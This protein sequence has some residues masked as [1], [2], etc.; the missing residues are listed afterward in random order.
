MKKIFNILL[1]CLLTLTA[2]AQD[3]PTQ[4]RRLRVQSL[5]QGAV[6]TEL[7]YQ[8]EKQGEYG[9]TWDYYR[10]S[11]D[12]LDVID[13]QMPVG[14]MFQIYTSASRG[15][16]AKGWTVNGLPY[17]VK[18]RGQYVSDTETNFYYVMPDEDI[19]LVGRFEY[20]PDAPDFQPGANA[21]DPETGTLIMDYNSDYPAG[22]TYEDYD[23]VLRFITQSLN[24]NIHSFKNCLVYDLSRSTIETLNGGNYGGHM[25]NLS[26][27]EILLPST[28]KKIE[29]NAFMGT[30]LQTLICFAMTP[31][32]LEFNTEYNEETG[33][34]EWVESGKWAF[35][36]CP[37]MVVRV[38]AEAVELYKQAKGW[39]D[40]T[41][42]AIDQNY[43]N[44]SVKLMDNP[45]AAQLAQYKNMSLELTSL[46]SGQVRRLL[47]SG[48]NQYAFTYLPEN[49]NYSLALVNSRGAAVGQIDNIFLQSENLSV[50]FPQLKNVHAL[51][52]TIKAGGQTMLED[53]F[54]N[55]WLAADNSYLA[56]GTKLDDMLD[57]QTVKYVVTLER[58]LASQYE[59]PDTTVL[60]V[61]QEGQPDNIVLPL[62]PLKNTTVTFNVVD[63]TTHAGIDNAV[64]Q[65]SQILPS[66][67]TGQTTSLTTGGDGRAVGEALA[68]WSHITVTSPIHGS[69]SFNVN[70][71]DSTVFTTTFTQADGTLLTLSHTYQAAVAE[72][73]EPSVQQGYTDGRSLNYEFTAHLPNGKDSVITHYLSNYPRYT[74]YTQLPEGTRL[75]VLASSAK[76]DIDPVEASAVVGQQKEAGVTLP[77]VQ[78]G[79]IE[80]SYYLSSSSHPAVLLFKAE[81][82]ELVKKEAFGEETKLT[83]EGLQTGNYL[84]AAM[85]QGTQYASI[86]SKSQ[87]EQ[88]VEDTD[89]VTEQVSISDG[90]SAKVRFT[91]VPLTM[92]QLESHLAERRAGFGSGTGIVG[93]NVGITAKIAFKGLKERTYRSTYDES[94]YPT[95]CRLEMYVP[96][97]FSKPSAYRSYRRYY[98][99]IN[100]HNVP[101]A[102]GGGGGSINSAS[103]M[104]IGTIEDV[105]ASGARVSKSEIELI[106]ATTTWDEATR[107][108]TIEWPHYDEGGKMQLSMIPLKA[109]NYTPEV[110]LVYTLNGKEEREILETTSIAVSRSGIQAP[111]LIVKPTFNVKGTAMYFEPEEDEAADSTATA[112]AAGPRRAMADYYSYFEKYYEV[113]VMAG[114]QPIGKAMINSKGEWRTTCTLPN[115]LAMDTY[116]VYAKITYKNGVSYQTES[117]KVKYDPNGVIPLSVKMSFFNHHP[118]HLQEQVVTFDLM[119][120][121]TNPHS[122]GYS[123]EEGYNTDFTFEIN[124]S[125]N[126]TTKVYAVDLSVFTDGPDAE[127]F[128][129][130]AHYNA[131][132]NRWIAYEKF[133]TRSMPR[134]V[135]VTPY[136]HGDIIGSREKVANALSFY[137]NLLTPDMATEQLNNQATD[138]LVQL[139]A[140]IDSNDE[141][142]CKAIDDQLYSIYTQIMG[143]YGLQIDDTDFSEA[144]EP[145]LNVDIDEIIAQKTYFEQAITNDL[146]NMNT[147]GDIIDGITTAP[148][149]G[150]TDLSLQA[151]GYERYMMDD[152]STLYIR[153]DDETGTLIVVSL[154]DDLKITYK[155]EILTSRRATGRRSASAD[156]EAAAET[157]AQMWET[158]SE[159]SA[160]ISEYQDYLSRAIDAMNI[161][162][163]DITTKQSNV[164]TLINKTKTKPGLSAQEIAQFNKTR[165]D[166]L[167]DLA[168]KSR[169]ACKTRSALNFL[170]VGDAMG[171]VGGFISLINNLKEMVQECQK[172]VDFYHTIP[173][174]CPHNQ[175]QADQL[176]ADAA[177]LAWWA[178]G[179]STKKIAADVVSITGSIAS[180]VGCTTIVAAPEGLMGLGLSV[181]C[182]ALTKIG[183]E[184]FSMRIAQE[185]CDLLIE[186]NEMECTEKKKTKKKDPEKNCTSNCNE[187]CPNTTGTL[188]PSG[189][190][191]EGVES[192]RLEGAT[193]TVFYKKLT[194]NEFGD[195]VEK[196]IVWDAENYGQ[197]NPQ[198]TDE[199]GEYGWMVPTGL[200]QVK[201]EKKGYQTEYSEWLPVPPPQLDVNQGMTQFSQPVVSQVKATQDGV[202]VT[203]D[204][205][206][207]PST[208]SA[209]NI[210]VTMNGQAVSGSVEP[211]FNGTD[212]LYVQ[213]ADF[214][215]RTSLP[216]GQ[217][218]LLTV[219]GNVESYAGIEMGDA[220]TQEFDITQAVNALIADSAVHVVYDQTTAVTIQAMP[221]AAA[222]GK[223]ASVKILSDMIV[224]ANTDELTFNEQGYA[225]LNLTGEA[226]GTTAAIIQMQDDSDVQKVV[227]VNVKEESDFICPM[228]ESNYMPG[229]AY[230]YGTMIELTCELPEAEIY[231][232]L[233]DTCPCAETSTSVKKYIAPIMLTTDLTIKA[234]AKAKGYTDSDIAQLVFRLDTG[235]DGISTLRADGQPAA[236]SIYTLSGLKVGNSKHMSKGVYIRDG[237]K[238]VVR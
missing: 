170:K 24:G 21:W 101:S 220:Y 83:F 90:H 148:A 193:T 43:V 68:T 115:A 67:I 200:W 235:E 169:L 233:D 19:Q 213:R 192:N 202:Q 12:T 15:Y 223:K 114:N 54:S 66:G 85:S 102:S 143:Y 191:Y 45:T 89:Y 174:P 104:A 40:F 129:I 13:V 168:R 182:M 103:F 189:F 201:Y 71:A 27:N 210:S 237:K 206:M 165:Y 1:L 123:N 127:H 35:P 65:V 106:A 171:C 92:T 64:V 208:L 110:Y 134:N 133:N 142:R 209:E 186:Y 176:R 46:S 70:L 132:K 185:Y 162:I 59:Q 111:D 181:G 49:T 164:L 26:I 29:R 52:L 141:A 30:K 211:V 155:N 87:L 166:R 31:P 81:T 161:Y 20:D 47:M 184:Y 62:E 42:L 119:E 94:L 150:M 37:E 140:A 107:K 173:N 88:Y 195:D 50:T 229:Q 95:D 194:K 105:V 212:T 160:K 118:E 11:T 183:D 7:R 97:G 222:A 25:S 230:A 145:T 6:T 61:G 86:K 96:E 34:S 128:M 18:S 3:A 14:Q 76:N 130:P 126:D 73:E 84:V 33:K 198:V 231:Y 138:L 136:Y 199:N 113:T 98:S 10:C 55:M 41:I 175:Y 39:R 22:F 219:S 28:L 147:L 137:K 57:G 36:D 159:I 32:E 112:R 188:D 153:P 190:V 216:I 125:N 167:N 23:K 232:T 72:D 180:L 144:D 5:P 135:N 121:E 2:A 109:G 152:G 187:C 221:A 17:D 48:R 99:L 56:R 163:N 205:Y 139:Q 204:K 225:T 79:Y 149:T 93:Q 51:S 63:E 179:Y 116:D 228:P 158:L 177:S 117:K 82:G 196:V 60:I 203:F 44:L 207:Q 108:L 131:R 53:Q 156:I 238:I 16:V 120:R 214:I 224:T 122:Y 146:K 157:I 227:V 80:A 4:T 91:R 58:Q 236:K 74:F 151:E 226:H 172:I 178:A 100:N 77:I 124:L 218:L 38:P 75:T 9:T 154:K 197:V 215:P 8:I 78:R 69:K 217:K 234:F